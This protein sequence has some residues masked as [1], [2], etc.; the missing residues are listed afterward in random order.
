MAMDCLQ[1]LMFSLIK[2]SYK[3][4]KENAF[5]AC[6]LLAWKQTY[7]SPALEFTVDL[8]IPPA[9]FRASKTKVCV[10]ASY[11][12]GCHI[13]GTFWT[14]SFNTLAVIVGINFVS[15]IVDWLVSLLVI[16]AASKGKSGSLGKSGRQ[17]FT[18]NCSWL[19]SVSTC[20][21]I[22]MFSNVWYFINLTEQIGVEIID[23]LDTQR[24]SLIRTQDR[25][26]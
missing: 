6:Y 4:M 17:S 1:K 9:N 20:L 23:E 22:R 12:Q 13:H 3:C 14:T 10:Q 11:L 16:Q 7:V 8:S 18:V 5:K 15:D 26:C 2:A 21:S 19:F 24:D 25:V